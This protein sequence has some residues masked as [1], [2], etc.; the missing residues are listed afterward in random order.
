MLK[1]LTEMYQKKK[2]GA[3]CVTEDKKT[4]FSQA[5]FIDKIWQKTD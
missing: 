2:D 5:H 1:K 3:D 4:D